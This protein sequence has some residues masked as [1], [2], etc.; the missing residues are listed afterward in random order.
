MSAIVAIEPGMK[1]LQWSNANSKAFQPSALVVALTND[2]LEKCVS[3][4]QIPFFVTTTY[5]ERKE[6]PLTALSANRH[7]K[8]THTRLLQHLAGTHNISRP[9]FRQIEPEV[10]AFMDIPGSKPKHYRMS[11]IPKH[12]STFHHH[13]IFLC[14]EHYA[15]LMDALSDKGQARSF[16][17]SNREHCQLRSIHVTR[18]AETTLDMNRVVSY[19]THY[20]GKFLERNEWDWMYQIYP[21]SNSEFK[22]LH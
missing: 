16:A 21:K 12:E 1:G 10:H 15:P 6:M 13:S 19:C 11:S 4:G 17:E 3:K 22:K 18:I 5:V 9:W 7:L 20:A 14:N 2:F 8:A